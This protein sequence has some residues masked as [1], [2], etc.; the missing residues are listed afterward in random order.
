MLQSPMDN[1]SWGNG[2]KS[3]QR[4]LHNGVSHSISY[5]SKTL[6]DLKQDKNV[7]KYD[8]KFLHTVIR[9]N[10]LQQNYNLKNN[11]KENSSYINK[12]KHFVT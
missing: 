7:I 9:W 3:S 5:T 8:T 4:F 2:H 12:W 1:L 10:N 6:E 11:N